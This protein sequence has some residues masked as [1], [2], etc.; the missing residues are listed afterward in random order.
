MAPGAKAP[1][2]QTVIIVTILFILAWYLALYHRGATD[3]LTYTPTQHE[4]INAADDDDDGET[5]ADNS[6]PFQPDTSETL[7]IDTRPAAAASEAPTNTPNPYITE[8]Q[9]NPT[10]RR[11]DGPLSPPADDPWRTLIL[12]AFSD[13][14]D[15]RTNLRYFLRHGL[16]SAADFIFIMNGVSKETLPTFQIPDEAS[17]IR[18][19]LRDNT[20]FDIGA[21][22]EV[23]RSEE[24]WT[25]VGWGA[26]RIP[27]WRRYKR[28][29][30]LNSSVRGPFLPHWG[31]GACW[32]DLFV[33]RVT[34]D[35]KLVGL[36]ANC[37][38]TFHVQ[39]DIWATDFVGIDLLI[40]PPP[41]GPNSTVDD[42]ADKLAP[43]G[44]AACYPD[45][46][47]AVHAELGATRVML[48]AGWKVDV[49]MSAFHGIANYS[50]V[51]DPQQQG[52]L[53]WKDKYFG[54]NLHPYE[55]V[56]TKSNRDLDPLLLERLTEWHWQSAWRSWDACGAF[57]RW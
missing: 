22:G 42:F 8:G 9:L 4:A 1:A 27:L 35:T 57:S 5:P 55:T 30:M 45:L 2:R 54:T 36:T 28:F 13:T 44:L 41:S 25:S 20:C 15:A 19:V 33:Q 7:E 47:R 31:Q 34:V 50:Q 16:H 18:V 17:N 10:G 26:N 23:L 49:M 40:N 11:L 14:P 56:F 38:P 48:E 43:V 24:Q 46:S 29:I 52:D 37:W 51:C 3:A 32:S 21:Y 12:Y 39:A 6:D 53:L